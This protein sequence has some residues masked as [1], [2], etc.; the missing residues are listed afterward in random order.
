MVLFEFFHGSIYHLIEEVVL[1]QIHLKKLLI[2]S[3]YQYI[4]EYD[5]FLE[6][7]SD[8]GLNPDPRHEY[9]L[10]SNELTIVSINRLITN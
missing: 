4:L 5:L 9:K 6:L 8:V 3:H 2:R 10:P 1:S 7:A